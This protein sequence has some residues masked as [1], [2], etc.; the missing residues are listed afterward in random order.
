MN[1]S[2]LERHFLALI[3]KETRGILATVARAVLYVLSGFFFLGVKARTLAFDRGWLKSYVPPVPLVISIGNITAGGTG[4]TP[5]TL[6][7]AQALRGKARLAIL[8]RGYRAEAESLAHPLLLHKEGGLWHPATLCGD[9][10]CL[11]AD[12]LPEAFIIVGKSRKQGSKMAARLGAQLLLLDDG[13]Q[14]RRIARDL[15]VVV[16]DL[17]DPFGQGYFLPRGLLREGIDALC[18]ADLVVINHAEDLKELEEVKQRITQVTSA[19]VVATR[20]EPVGLFNLAG[21]PVEAEGPVAL[22]CGIAHPEY[23][24]KTVKEMGLPIVSAYPLA[25]HEP[26]DLGKLLP[27][28]Q[29]CK[30]LGAT[31]LLCTE[32]DRVKIPH[33]DGLPLPVYWVKMHLAFVE[34]H[35]H[36]NHFVHRADTALRLAG[37]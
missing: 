20:V 17:R 35:N 1:L 32:K 21:L 25:D 5:V 16:L 15:E 37:R 29:E 7:L 9:E 3:R 10:P 31:C 33:T 30:A 27:F 36:W 26:L 22:F 34:G 18:R 12:N 4:K 23:F 8:A 11:L 13:M 6:A 14:H 28:A 2:R 24:R 19:P